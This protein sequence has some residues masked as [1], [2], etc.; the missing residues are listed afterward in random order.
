MVK[1]YNNYTNYTVN[2][3]NKW[4]FKQYFMESKCLSYR[5]HNELGPP[6][7]KQFLIDENKQ[8]EN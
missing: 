3:V 6:G 4:H 7:A 5:N 8:Q 1:I 2:K